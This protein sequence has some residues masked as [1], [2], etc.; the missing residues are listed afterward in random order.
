MKKNDDYLPFEQK[1][2]EKVEKAIQLNSVDVKL[3]NAI[4]NV[5]YETVFEEADEDLNELG[6]SY[7]DGGILKVIWRD[8]FILKLKWDLNLQ[9]FKNAIEDHISNGEWYKV[10]RLIEFTI[11][12]TDLAADRKALTEFFNYEFE[13]HNSGYRVVREKIIP[14][15][16]S[17]EIH[18]VNELLSSASNNKFKGLEKHI[19]DAIEFLSLK[20][21]SKPTSSVRESITAVEWICRNL[22]N[23]KTLGDALKELT[24]IEFIPNEISISIQKLYEFTNS[25]EGIRHAQIADESLVSLDEARFY[26]ISCSAIGNYLMSIAAKKGVKLGNQEI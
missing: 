9:A 10:Y 23:T 5:F 15:T 2:G 16:N 6:S 22:T 13:K 24:K 18:S 7:Y 8:Y 25:K 12:N 21:E 4:Y 11:R 19:S 3:R 20:P 1:Y 26:L 17:A 14:I